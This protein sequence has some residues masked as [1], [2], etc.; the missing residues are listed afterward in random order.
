MVVDDSHG[1][2]AFGETGR[3][4]EE[5]TGNAEA[6]IL[7]AILGKASGVNGGYFTASKTLTAYLRETPPFYIYNGFTN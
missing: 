7:V 5:V 2:G 3:G 6:D 1:A 4:T